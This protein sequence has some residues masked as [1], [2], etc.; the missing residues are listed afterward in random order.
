MG[1]RNFLYDRNY[2]IDRQRALSE[3]IR[4][5]DRDEGFLDRELGC[6]ATEMEV[7]VYIEELIEGLDDVTISIL[8]GESSAE[9]AR[10]EGVSRQHVNKRHLETMSKIRGK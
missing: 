10:N 2:K 7:A 6:D 5:S 8:M 4:I 1:R 9:V 3:A